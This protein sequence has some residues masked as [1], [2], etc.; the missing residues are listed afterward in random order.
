[1]EGKS[2]YPPPN[3]GY[4][5]AHECCADVPGQDAPCNRDPRA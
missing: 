3:G 5:A 4:G 1:V 2:G